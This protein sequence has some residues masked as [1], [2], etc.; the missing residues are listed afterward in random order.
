MLFSICVTD[1]AFA[2]R[3]ARTTL[4]YKPCVFARCY[5]SDKSVAHGAINLSE[6]PTGTLVG[7]IRSPVNSAIRRMSLSSISVAC[8]AFALRSRRLVRKYALG[9]RCTGLEVDHGRHV[10]YIR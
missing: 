2:P 10:R 1:I 6:A 9:V 3:R 4:F 8:E 7:D 5:V